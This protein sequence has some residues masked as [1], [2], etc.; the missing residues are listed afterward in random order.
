M[1]GL[2]LA[3]EYYQTFGATMI[4][5]QFAD[6]KDRIAIGLVGE[7]SECLGYD[8]DISKDHDFSVGFSLFI[9]REDERQFGFRLERAYSKLP[10]EFCGVKRDVLSPAGGN[11]TGVVTI[12]DFYLKHLGVESIARDDLLWWLYTPS[13]ALLASSNGEVF[14]D[15]LGVFSANRNVLLG[16]YPEDVR[17]KKLAAHTAFMAQAGQ[18]NYARCVERGETGAAQLAIFEY[19]R[20]AISAIYLL[21]NKY[22]PFYKW[23]YRGMRDLPILGSLELS[24]V[25]LT[26]LDNAPKYAVEKMEIVE[27]VA[28]MLITEYYNQGITEA[29]CLDL[30]KHAYSILDHV[31]SSELR[32]LHIMEGV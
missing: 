7:G 25:G 30:E 5:E 16:G 1:Q 32:N 4:A 23:A 17:L 13:T 28:K 6:V 12:E 10:K 26:E 9:T 8:D 11:R 2:D 14:A 18:Y 3:R 22:E 21:N 27:D 29:S 31:K 19:V 20:H 15:P 24:L